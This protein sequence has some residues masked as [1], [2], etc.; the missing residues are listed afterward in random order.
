MSSDLL[1][2]NRVY[3]EYVQ[4]NSY[5]RPEKNYLCSNL[6][7]SIG[8]RVSVPE[9]SRRSKSFKRDLT[10]LAIAFGEKYKDYKYVLAL[11]GGIDSEVTAETFYEQG[12]TFRAISQRLFEGANDYDIIYAAKY[13]QDRKI[14]HKVINLPLDKMMKH[15]IPDAV[16]YGQFTHSYSQIALCNLFN[17]VEDDEIIIFSGHNPDFHRQI[18]VGWWEDSP[19][20]IKYAIAKDKRFFTFTS[21]EPIFC[22]Y[23][24]NFDGDQPGEKNNDFLYEAFPHLTRRV[25]M[26]GWEKSIKLVGGLEDEIRKYCAFRMQTFITW[27]RFTLNYMRKIF[28]ERE[29]ERSQNE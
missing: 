6:I 16:K 29:I 12:I 17:Y 3:W 26:T 10:K 22:H 11:S 28:I 14:P 19:N 20:I 21:L 1:R 15:T 8:V 4:N 13:C 23:A 7:P 5:L 2:L 24:S 18:G 27:E 25:K 9:Y